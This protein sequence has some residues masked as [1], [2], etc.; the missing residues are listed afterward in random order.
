MNVISFLIYCVIVTI[1]P[2][3]TNI[4]ILS[5]SHNFKIKKTFR[6]VFG[7]TAAM[8]TLL[9]ASVVLNSVIITVI[10]KII[11]IMQIIGSLYILYLAYHVLKMNISDDSIMQS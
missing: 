1:T 8:G 2:G 3:P 5:I 6:F 4:A 11:I 7:V 9:T 10:P